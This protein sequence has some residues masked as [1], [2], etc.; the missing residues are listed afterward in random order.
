MPELPARDG[1]LDHQELDRI[2]GQLLWQPLRGGEHDERDL[3]AWPYH[4]L[5]RYGRP[6]HDELLPKR[7]GER[8][9]VHLPQEL[10]RGRRGPQHGNRW[11]GG[12][13]QRHQVLGGSELLGYLLGQ[14]R[15][16]EAAAG[17]EYA[18]QRGGLRL[19][20]APLR[21]AGRGAEGPSAGQLHGG[22]DH[23]GPAWTALGSCRAR[24][25]CHGSNRVDGRQGIGRETP[26]DDAGGGG[27][28]WRGQRTFADGGADS[29][30]RTRPVSDQ[31]R[32]PFGLSC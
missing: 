6:L 15:V 13:E 10:H 3:C 12:V 23:Q 7:L 28:G 27:F 18:P 26:G 14:Q 17:R 1:V 5:L 31:V 22:D 20:G 11:L 9:G 32:A 29:E 8:W 16:A 25:L 21:A 19:V 30:G 2:W 4:L 24:G